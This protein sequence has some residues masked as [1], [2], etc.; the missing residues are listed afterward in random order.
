MAFQNILF[1][2]SPVIALG[3][4]VDER[5]FQKGHEQF[6]EVIK[7]KVPQLGKKTVPIVTDREVGI[8]NTITKVL[9]NAR[10]LICWNH[11]LR[12]LKF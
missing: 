1:D 10:S 2:E 8:V 3:F 11:I 7:E 5:K 6:L 9:P 4:M 12:D